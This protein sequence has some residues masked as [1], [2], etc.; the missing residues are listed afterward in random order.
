[1]I[2]RMKKNKITIALLSGLFLLSSCSD[3]LT[4]ENLM[5]MSTKDT[6]SSEVGVTSVVANLYTRLNYYQDFAKDVESYD[7]TRWDE[8][9]NN[10]QYW[11]FAGNVGND[12]RL[13]D[14]FYKKTYGLIWE[15]NTHIVNLTAHASNFPLE[16]YKYFL[17]EARYIRAY[18]YFTLVTRLGG[19]P[20][21]TEAQAY[22]SDPLSLA[23]PRNKEAD[24]YDFIASEVDDAL[25]GFENA[26]TKTRATKGS[27]LALKSRAMLYAGTIAYNYDKGAEIGLNLKSGAT[28]I[29]KSKANDYFKKCLD[30]CAELEKLGYSLYSKNVNRSANYSEAFTAAYN[31]NSEIIFC[32]AY[33]GVN[34]QNTF[35]TKAIA[36][37]QR[38]ADKTG[39]QINPV[40]NLVNCFEVVA[41]HEVKDMD[42]YVGDEAIEDMGVNT[43][44]LEYNVYDKAEDIFAGRDPRL[45][46]TVLCPGSISR[47]KALDFQA[48]LAIPNGDSYDFKASKNITGITVDKHDGQKLTGEDG[49]LCDGSDNCYISHTGFLLNKYVDPIAG[50]ENNGSSKVAYI[51]FRYG[52]ALL[53]AA[54]A[55]FYLSENGVA[56]YN[57]KT[58]KDLALDYIN[59]VRKR[60][61]G[62][63]FM[64]NANELTFDRI[65]NERRVE[66]AFEDH[67]YYDLKRW[68]LADDVWHFDRDSETANLYALWPYKIYAPGSVDN[69]KWIYRKVK[70]K[71]RGGASDKGMPLS[72]T[73]SM[74]Y[75]SYPMDKG[76]PYIEKNPN[77]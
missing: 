40:L 48:G 22:T 74:Y 23:K 36:R 4:Q 72:F 50:S 14:D 21:I 15:V 8:A 63:A 38:G 51:V 37:S 10:S 70:V 33:E 24:I 3:W 45:L 58:T 66:L 46:G 49:P 60:A 53:N 19:V 11:G 59:Q 26:F 73:R 16:K 30:A 2:E 69:G 62:D 44:N 25:A 68:R 55:A 13:D 12:Y 76:N 28:G 67:R 34:I 71:H 1:M 17:A 52:E 39:A 57:G 9:T 65:V 64:L 56:E 35:T 27:A 42:A 77:Q 31:D 43:S 54:E 18:A 32:K 7:L 61:G 6:Y 5:G 20:L 29:D 47:G 75:G 41:T